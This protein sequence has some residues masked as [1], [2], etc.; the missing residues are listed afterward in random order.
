MIHI[1]TL[2]EGVLHKNR[3]GLNK[4]KYF[5]KNEKR[6]YQARMDGEYVRWETKVRYQS[7]DS[8]NDGYQNK[9]DQR[10]VLE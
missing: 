8:K 7:H 4:R 5:S 9:I 3:I 10:Q 1:S 6:I 2:C